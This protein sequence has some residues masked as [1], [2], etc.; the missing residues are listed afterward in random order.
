MNTTI[1]KAQ[2]EAILNTASKLFGLLVE[3]RQLDP[4]SAEGKQIY[5]KFVFGALD[6]ACPNATQREKL[7]LFGSPD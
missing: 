1:T 6:T 7:V 3:A 5:N 4:D 2:A